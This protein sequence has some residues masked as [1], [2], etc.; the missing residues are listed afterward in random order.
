MFYSPKICEKSNYKKHDIYTQTHDKN[1]TPNRPHILLNGHG[2]HFGKHLFFRFLCLQC[3]SETF[4]IK[5]H[6]IVNP[7]VKS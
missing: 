5:Q 1:F 4:L 3:L 6:L 2:H 7:Q